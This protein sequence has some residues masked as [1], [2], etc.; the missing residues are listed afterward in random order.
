MT[1]TVRRVL[2]LP[3]LIALLA[4]SVAAPA[5]ARNPQQPDWGH[6]G[7]G[8]DRDDGA[9]FFAAD[10]LRQDLVERYASRG[11]MPTMRSLLRTGTKASGNGL[12][13]QAPPNT[14]AG[15]Y[16]LA[17]GAWPG[18]HGSTNN[19]YHVNGSTFANSTSA[20][21]ANSLQAETIA[22]SAERAGLKVAQVEWAGGIQ[23]LTSGPTI[24]FRSFLSGR[25]VAT[26]YISPADSA[27]FTR[28]FGLQF[29]HPAGFAGNAPYPQAAPLPATG[30]TNVP[31][32]Y[33]PPKEMRLRVIDFGEDKYGLNAYLFDSRNDGRVNYNRV[34]F[35]PSK[36]GAAAV[37]TLRNGQ[38]ADVKVEIVGGGL[39][40]LTAGFWLKVEQLTGDLSQVRL[41]HTSVARAN[42][43]WATWPGE[44]GFTGDFAEFLAQR[45]P[46]STAGDFAV[47]EAGIV[48]EETYIEQGELWSKAHLPMLRYVGRTYKP[49]LLLVG[50][51]VTDEVQHQFLGLVTRTVPGGG[52]NPAY[53]DLNLDGV[54]D[55]RVAERREFI[56]DAYA[57]ADHVL[58]VAR[59]LVSRDPTTFVSSDHGFAP[60]FLAIDASKVLVDLNLLSTPQIS[61]CRLNSVPANGPVETIALAKA[62][63]AGGALQVYLKVEG[64]DCT[65]PTGQPAC[66]I[67]SADVAARVAAIR[68]AYAA[69][70]DPNDW[71]HDGSPD[72][73]K[74]IDRT[75]TKDE[76][77]YIPNG[78]GSTADMAH[79]TRTGDLVVFSYP[80]Y[81]FDAATPGTLIAPS[82][83]FGQHGYVPDVQDLAN[84]INMRATFIAGG[85][86]VDRGTVD[87]RTID[88][89][90]TLAFLLD[91]PVPQ[92][93]QGRVLLDV[94]DGGHRYKPINI[95]GLNDFHGQLSPTTLVYDSGISVPVGGAGQLATWF[96]EEFASLKRQGLIVAAGDNVGASPPN[97]GLLEDMPAIDVENAWG[98][99]ATSLGN[100]EFDYGIE[101]LQEHIARANFPFLASNVVETATGRIPSWLDGAVRR[102]HGQ[103]DQG[104]R[105]RRRAPG[106]SR[107][108]V[109]GRHR[110]HHVPRRGPAHPRRVRA[111]ATPRGQGPDRRD[112]RGDLD[113]PQRGRPDGCPALDR[114]DPFDRRPAAGH[115]GRRHG[116]RPHPPHLEP[117]VRAVPDRRG[118]QRGLELLGAPDDDPRRGRGVDRRVHARRQGHRRRPT[119]GRQ[120]DRRRGQHGG[121]PDPAAGRR[122][123]GRLDLPGPG[124][125]LGVG[126]GQ[127]RRGRDAR[128]VRR[129]GRGRVH[130][131]RRAARGYPVL[132]AQRR[133]G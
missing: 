108:R 64:R 14:G 32:S 94:A 70:T 78:P 44:P 5:T 133:G 91:V 22:Q 9:V 88:L 65:T 82:A 106:D 6:G 123:P 96:D 92:H 33:S 21:S 35:S 116:R 132:A 130:E 131:L 60:Q 12:L 119:A 87:A 36:D 66:G 34:L 50:F 18:V 100:H 47:L 125:G 24:D 28:S 25:G 75:F 29:D 61:N 109:G 56:E 45:F 40:G 127:P 55:G 129:R 19:T 86:G 72:G 62:C 118:H 117:R 122:Q 49:D 95:L 71:N 110:G 20:F 8:H 103:R 43:R 52:P 54:R 101:R 4:S 17:T 76:S 48:S 31:T 113:G 102:V 124:P 58:S 126:D 39:A 90:P 37:A 111:A 77:R 68:A 73:M 13:T 97:S 104:R 63:W 59:R 79:P 69:I 1:S 26:N 114:S 23:A 27:A 67:R 115:D 85:S 83:F 57:E 41:F 105:H 42:A 89:A 3:V 7:G 10:G 107:A 16:S 84:N 98:L 80:P 11:L 46:S 30:W 81:Q 15:W 38:W 128:Q 120:G 93:S 99:D 112:P 53:D 121:G 51:P 2:L 74:V